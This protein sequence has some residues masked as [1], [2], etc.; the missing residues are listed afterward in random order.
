MVMYA[1][2]AVYAGSDPVTVYEGVVT[3]TDLDL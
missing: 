3:C 2:Y 1:V